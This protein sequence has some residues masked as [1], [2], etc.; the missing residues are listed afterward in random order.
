[1]DYIKISA[2]VVFGWGI[3]KIN[4]REIVIK[5][6]VNSVFAVAPT[7]NQHYITGK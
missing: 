2:I 4:K 7:L 5:I 6:T 1:M 3:E